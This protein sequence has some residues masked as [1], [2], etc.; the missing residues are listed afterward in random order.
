[1]WGGARIHWSDKSR[2]LLY[3]TYGRPRVWRRL[4]EAYNQQVIYTT[5]PFCGGSVMVWGRISYVCKLDLITIILTLNAK[6]YQQEVLD[7]TVIPHFDNHP[8]ATRPVLMDDNARTHRG[9]A[10]IAAHAKQC[11][12]DVTM[13]SKES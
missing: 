1:M 5:E 2:F 13:A 9:R 6:W 11:R 10:V 12:R 3:K 4:N 7:A 8:F